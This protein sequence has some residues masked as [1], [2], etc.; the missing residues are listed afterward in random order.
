MTRD[1]WVE[2]TGGVDGVRGLFYGDASQLAA[3]LPAA[4]SLLLFGFIV[5]FVLFKASNLALPKRVRNEV[6][7]AA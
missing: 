7:V 2:A 1:T 5:S 6:E 3:Q 4:L